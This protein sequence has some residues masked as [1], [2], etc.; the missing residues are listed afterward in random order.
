MAHFLPVDRIV[1][2]QGTSSASVAAPN[3]G[4]VLPV[5]VAGLTLCRVGFQDVLHGGK[6]VVVATDHNSTLFTALH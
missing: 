3:G 6:I 4:H 2:T 1:S 5:C